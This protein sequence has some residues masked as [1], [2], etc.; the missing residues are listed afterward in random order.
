MSGSKPA[1]M[2][3]LQAQNPCGETSWRPSADVYRTRAGWVLKYD[4]AGVRPEDVRV[5]ISGR[6]IMVSGVRRDWAMEQGWTHYSMEI[7]YSRFERTIELPEPVS[8]YAMEY[9]DGILLVQVR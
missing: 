3:F 5:S 7:C 8:E 4:L 9:R 1:R 2:F 6:R